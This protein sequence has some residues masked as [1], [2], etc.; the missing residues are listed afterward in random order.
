M[1]LER[2]LAAKL[3]QV[4]IKNLIQDLRPYLTVPGKDPFLESE[5]LPLLCINVMAILSTSYGMSLSQLS[6]SN[7]A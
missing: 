4:E 3:T 7:A 1:A 6:C 5:Y 2:K